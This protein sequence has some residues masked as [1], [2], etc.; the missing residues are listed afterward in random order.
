MSHRF[1]LD[2][3]SFEQVLCATSLMQQLNRQVRNGRASNHDDTQPLSD[4]V[5]AQLAIETDTMDLQAAMNRVVGLALTLGRATGAA[6]WLFTGHEF[7]YRAGTGSGVTDERLQLEVLSKLAS[8]CGPSDRSPHDPRESNH[9]S[10]PPDAIPYPGSVKSLLVV[11][12]YHGRNIAGAL[13]VFSAEFNAFTE[14]D[15][16]KAHLLSGLLTHALG[17]AAEADLKQKVSL[18]RATMLQ[19]IDQL[20]PALRKLAEIE[21]PESYRSPNGFLS[22]LTEFETVQAPGTISQETGGGVLGSSDSPSAI[23]VATDGTE[24]NP[25]DYPMLGKGKE[26]TCDVADPSSP[27]DDLPPELTC[28]VE[29]TGAP[30]PASSSTLRMGVGAAATG[31][32]KDPPFGAAISLTESAHRQLSKAGFWLS[33]TMK[34]ILG[35]PLSIAKFQLRISI[36]A[37]VGRELRVLFI[38]AVPAAA[39]LIMLVFL[40]FITST[41]RRSN[42]AAAASET[43]AAAKLAPASEPSPDLHQRSGPVPAYQLSHLQVTDPATSSALR[44]LSRYEIV[45]LRRRAVYGD[46]SAALL[47]GM[48]YETGHLVPQ[49]CVRAGEWVARSAN[50]GNAAAQYNLG[51]RYRHGDGEPVNEEVGARWL[52]KAAAQ[53]YSPAQLALESVP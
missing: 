46:D 49:N 26:Q 3:P 19:A 15:A 20:I 53:K 30:A 4:L 10:P 43:S 16:T 9:W 5:E 25:R 51:L 1:T 7:V 23:E 22:L 35:A 39:L 37:R 11:P 36:P 17:K 2:R 47:L 13:A 48:A 33:T 21:K 27:A 38:A 42:A 32:Q 6:T 40:F 28:A 34:H 14:R 29:S 12:I 45:G 41:G 52:R 31:I 8:L 44:T 18:E 50:E 24:P